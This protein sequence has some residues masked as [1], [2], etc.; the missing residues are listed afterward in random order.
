MKR[1]CV[2]D[3]HTLHKID[4]LSTEDSC[5][6]AESETIW[7]FIKVGCASL[8]LP[9]EFNQFLALPLFDC[10]SLK[11]TQKSAPALAGMEGEAKPKKKKTRK[12]KAATKQKGSQRESKVCSF[13]MIPRYLSTIPHY[14]PSPHTLSSHTCSYHTVSASNAEKGTSF[15]DPLHPFPHHR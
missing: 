12:P 10:L 8:A 15:V 2:S 1:R 9:K 7:H 11:H 13:A 5:L 14:L 4:I 6:L 3:K